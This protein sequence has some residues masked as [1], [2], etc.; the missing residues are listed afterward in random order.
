MQFLQRFSNMII[1]TFAN[2]QFCCTSDDVLVGTEVVLGSTQR[3]KPL[4]HPAL[5][6]FPTT[7][8]NV[9]GQ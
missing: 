4:V 2:G 8:C 9:Q 1:Y 3:L 5:I 7:L 6:Y